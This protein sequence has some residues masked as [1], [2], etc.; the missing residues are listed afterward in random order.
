MACHNVPVSRRDLHKQRTRK[1]ITDAG[2]RLFQERGFE[3]V[4]VAEIAEA[5][6]V[7]PRT[8]HRYFRTGT[9][10]CSPTRRSTAR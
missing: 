2:M 9:S 6:D 4:T 3:A 7:A 8:F 10:C 1:A 5:A